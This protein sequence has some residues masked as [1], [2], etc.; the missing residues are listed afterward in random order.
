MNTNLSL[1]YSHRSEAVLI[2]PGKG[3]SSGE[4]LRALRSGL[5]PEDL[6]LVVRAVWTPRKGG[7][8]IEFDG[9]VKDRSKLCKRVT[10]AAGSEVGVRHLVS[11]TT[12]VIE[13]WDAARTV[14][15]VKEAVRKDISEGVDGL[16]LSITQANK[17]GLD[18]AATLEALG[19]IKFGW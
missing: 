13:G 14:E 12:V 8:L 9:S 18:T 15:E 5:Q 6:G 3:K 7:L 17:W 2:N 10:E 11:T 1:F 16:K 19:K 4:V